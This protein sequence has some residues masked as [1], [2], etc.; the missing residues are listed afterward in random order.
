MTDYIA[1]VIEK[2][3][4]LEKYENPTLEANKM[5]RL[6]SAAFYAISSIVIVF[7]NKSVLTIYKFPSAQML[8]VG[9]MI[10]AIVI[11]GLLKLCGRIEFPALTADI[12]KRI[13]PLPILYLCNMIF[14][15]KSTKSLSLPMFTVLRRFSILMTMILE[16]LVLKSVPTR[17]VVFSVLVM[18]FGAMI[19]ASNDL[20]FDVI[21]YCFILANDAF[22]ASYGVFTKKQLNCKDLGKYGLLFY[23]CLF[24][25][26]LVLVLS[27]YTGDIAAVQNFDGWN[28]P[29]FVFQFILS[30]FMGFIL[31]YS[32]L[33]CTQMNSSLTTTVV[34]CMKNL[35]VTYAGMMF[36]GDYIF[37]VVNFVGINISVFGSLLY[38][39]YAFGRTKTVTTPAI[40]APL[41]PK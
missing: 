11:L 10:A 14:G 21:A 1:T 8:G 37:A 26:P 17:G 40:Q 34:G 27:H 31:M 36:G 6:A 9:Q 30:C 7:V 5:Q 22:T 3:Y 13:F 35:F 39:Y 23:N 38:S 41:I 15:L 32:I 4:F 28:N 25:L 33:L 24:S 12:P 20:A 29:M 19:A 2:F 18:I 16:R